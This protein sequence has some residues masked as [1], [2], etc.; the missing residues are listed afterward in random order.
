MNDSSTRE[1]GRPVPDMDRS[2][3][4]AFAATLHRLGDS[5]LASC[6]AVAV[7]A[8]ELC[9]G[10]PCRVEFA[11]GL[12]DG[13]VG[14]HGSERDPRADEDPG[15]HRLRV[16]SSGPAPPVEPGVRLA[17][18]RR[19]DESAP[20]ELGR[21]RPL[22]T[23][24]GLALERHRFAG[25][26][27]RARSE[28]EAVEAAIEHALRGHLHGA[29]LRTDNLLLALRRDPPASA[30][31]VREQLEVLKG[32]V[33][34]MVEEISGVLGERGPR[35]TAP[36]EA[37]AG[38]REEVS[39]PELLREAADRATG[40]D[41]APGV[42]VE[43]EVPSVPAD[44]GRLGSALD[45]LFDLARRSTR[46]PTLSVRPHGPPSGVLVELSVELPPFSGPEDGPGN[47]GADA[48]VSPAG[49]RPGAPTGAGTAKNRASLREVVTR[50]GGRLRVEAGQ[51]TR[52][53]VVAIVPAGA[54]EG[55][56]A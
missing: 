22:V 14:G 29:L 34:E 32:T 24:A 49:E 1:R 16:S 45:E 40:G 39:L 11:G 53:T 55:P 9:G 41:G 17:V 56:G 7:K 28:A 23:L 47:P 31:E 43:G 42:D 51:G 4:A 54:G 12:Q 26:A 50:L 3:M 8:R 30:D 13:D 37:G 27:R 46:P 36:S 2:A 18:K 6:C 10:R 52:V 21:L 20:P 19:G 38:P 33:G 44:A 15:W 25:E 5:E 48:D 35:R